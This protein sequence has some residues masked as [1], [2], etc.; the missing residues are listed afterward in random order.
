MDWEQCFANGS[1]LTLWPENRRR[2]PYTW[3]LWQDRLLSV[4]NF[5]FWNRKPTKFRKGF[6]ATETAPALHKTAS[7]RLIPEGHP[8]APSLPRQDIGRGTSP[9][10]RGMV[11]CRQQSVGQ[12]RVSSSTHSVPLPYRVPRAHGTSASRWQSTGERTPGPFP[13]HRRSCPS[14][15]GCR[16]HDGGESK[17]PRLCVSL[18]HGSL[19]S[20]MFN[21]ASFLSYE[22]FCRSWIYFW[23]ICLFIH[24]HITYF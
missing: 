15:P 17:S 19:E 12:S 11:T 1:S 18:L 4:A 21:K 23:K 7:D 10:S 9:A 13:C 2:I 3:G 6:I 22:N 14:S 8:C 24:L 5:Y 16:S 20:L